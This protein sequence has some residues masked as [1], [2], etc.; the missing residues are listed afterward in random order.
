MKVNT[1]FSEGRE[2]EW[3][4]S[5]GE[6]QGGHI[7]PPGPVVLGTHRVRGGE[8]WVRKACAEQWGPGPGTDMGVLGFLS[9][10]CANTK[11]EVIS[12]LIAKGR[13]KSRDQSRGRGSWR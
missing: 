13:K 12:P 10:P 6:E 8:R 1:D 7:Q 3:S 4:G 5:T 9:L 2:G 11:D